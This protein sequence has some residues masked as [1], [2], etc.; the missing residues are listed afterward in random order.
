MIGGVLA[1]QHTRDMYFGAVCGCILSMHFADS[2]AQWPALRSLRILLCMP[3]C[4]NFDLPGTL[5]S[6]VYRDDVAFSVC[7]LLSTIVSYSSLIA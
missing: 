7:K 5:A 1:M 2:R 4:I 6:I 3:M